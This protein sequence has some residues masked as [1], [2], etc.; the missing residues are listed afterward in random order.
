MRGSGSPGRV[1]KEEAL[2]GKGVFHFVPR[3][4]D[5]SGHGRLGL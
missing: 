1:R 5:L 3:L 2:L 4:E